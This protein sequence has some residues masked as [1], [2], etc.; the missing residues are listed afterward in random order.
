MKPVVRIENNLA[1]MVNMSPSKKYLQR[2]WS[3]KKQL[4]GGMAYRNN[5]NFKKIFSETSTEVKFKII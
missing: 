5:K 4:P 2:I 3:V 1:E